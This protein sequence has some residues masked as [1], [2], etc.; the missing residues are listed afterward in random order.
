MNLS[1]LPQRGFLLVVALLLTVLISLLALG[2]LGIKKGSYSSSQA[3]LQAVQARALARSGLGDVWTKYSK[4][5]S[6]PG[7]LG[8]D[9]VRFSYRENVTDIDGHV[10]GSYV[11]TLD[12][13]DR[14]THHLIRVECT[15]I[16]GTVEEQATHHTIYA[17]L[18]TLPG[19]FRFKVWQEGTVPQL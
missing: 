18:H 17:E 5:P 13:S 3:A 11:V 8:D 14:L 7:G 4:D 15:G 2:M 10:L 1:R 19:D 6:F 12:R 9:Q 16:A